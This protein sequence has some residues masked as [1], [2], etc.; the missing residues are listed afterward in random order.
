MSNIEKLPID[1]I[2]RQAAINA[3][4]EFQY[5]EIIPWEWLSE[6]LQLTRPNELLTSDQFQK[7]QF[8]QLTRVDGFK[9][10]ML[11]QYE[12][13]LVNVRGQGYRIVEP[14]HQTRE[15]MAKLQKELRKAINDAMQALV[16]VN[17]KALT[18][19]DAR[20]NADARAKLAAFSKLHV[21][22]LSSATKPDRRFIE[23]K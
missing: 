16:N 7:L 15:A 23:K 19:D 17:A 13:Y 22:E 4:E 20:E 8:E 5:G 2:W 9:E 10:E 6:E 18:L 1:P 12:R 14:P 11:T 21:R 3:V